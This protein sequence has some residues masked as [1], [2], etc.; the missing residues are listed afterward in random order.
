MVSK[1]DR[2]TANLHMDLFRADLN[3][4]YCGAEQELRV[5]YAD[6]WH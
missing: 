5:T 2:T 6:N 4:A 1:W 3:S